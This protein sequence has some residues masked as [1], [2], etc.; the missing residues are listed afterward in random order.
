MPLRETLPGARW[1]VP[2]RWHL[3]LRFLG[4]TDPARVASLVPALD[5]LAAGPPLRLSYAG[6]GTFPAGGRPSVLWVGFAGQ[7]DR[8]AQLAAAADRAV[9]SSG[10]GRRDRPFR[11]HLTVARFGRSAG[12]WPP[13]GTLASLSSA[14]FTVDA[15]RLIRSHAGKYETLHETH[16]TGSRTR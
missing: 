14:E 1:V 3:T 16:L 13:A 5:A 12:G 6:L 4:D 7:L 10:A 11:P 9:D 8:L 15:V 2:E